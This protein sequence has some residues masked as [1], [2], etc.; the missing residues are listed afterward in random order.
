MAKIDKFRFELV[1]H[2]TLFPIHGSQRLSS[3]PKPATYFKYRW[4]KC[5]ECAANY[6]ITSLFS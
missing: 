1:S 2:L 3:I 4:K 5:V 6:I